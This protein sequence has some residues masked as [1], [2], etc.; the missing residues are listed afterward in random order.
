[1]RRMKRNRSKKKRKRD[2]GDRGRSLKDGEDE[3]RMKSVKKSDGGSI[4]YYRQSARDE[5]IR[6]Q[7][8]TLRIGLRATCADHM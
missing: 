3:G 7:V 6:I 1:M 2:S 8:M 4:E 5:V